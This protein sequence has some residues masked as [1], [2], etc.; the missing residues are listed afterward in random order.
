M[1]GLSYE[2]EFITLFEKTVDLVYIHDFNGRFLDA[3]PAALKLLG[4][5]KE[6]IGTADFSTIIASEQVDKAIETM[7]EIIRIGYQ[8]GF[9]EFIVRNKEGK[10][11]HIQTNG[12]LIYRN[13]KPYA[14][15]GI[16]RDIT[17][18]KKSEE[19]YKKIYEQLKEFRSIINRSPAIVLFWKMSHS[20]PV[21]F[22]SDNIRQFG[23][24]PEDFLS[25]KVSWTGIIH[26]DDLPKFVSEIADCARKNITE[27]YQEYR[28]I[29]ISGDVRWIGDHSKT[30]CNPQEENTHYQSIILDITK[31]K[32]AE[33]IEKRNTK[34]MEILAQK[35]MELVQIS[36]DENIYQ[37]IGNK[38][39]EI[40]GDA[41]II[42]NSCDESKSLLETR[43]VIGLGN[44]LENVVKMLKRHPVGM[45]FKLTDEQ[46][47]PIQR[48]K[49]E[50]I[51]GGIYALSFKMIPQIVCKTLESMLHIADIYGIGFVSKG[52]I[53][54]T[55]IIVTF[56]GA[57]PLDM[58]L[59]E[60]FC[61]QASVSLQRWL[62]EKAVRKS[63]EKYHRLTESIND[64]IY[65]I[66]AQG[67]ITHLGPQILRYGYSLDDALSRDF[68]EFVVPEDRESVMI[69]F[70]RSLTQGEEFPSQFRMRDKK[71]NIRWFEDNGMV[72][73]D[74]HGNIVGLTGI[75]RDITDRKQAEE[76]LK[77][78][79]AK[80]REQKTEL[81]QKNIALREIIG[82]IEIEKNTIKDDVITNVNEI[83]IPFLNKLTLEGESNEY[84]ILF[85][86][87]LENLTSSFGRKISED[88]LKLTPREIEITALIESGLTTKEISKILNISA[89]TVEKHRKNIRKK[90]NIT[91][92]NVNLTTF[93]Q[94]F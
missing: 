47:E 51:E 30:I 82:H 41:V 86:H 29:T 59:V 28:L 8:K 72:Q 76:A 38:L 85:R 9:T 54:G 80:L 2:D 33:N 91:H 71:G 52:N 19:K 73:R 69:D 1:T 48:G 64:I 87:M 75:L 15:L 81:E 23:Y 53:Y 11:I 32:S 24:Q 43:A 34:R 90:L 60:I 17:E 92:K 58:E 35:A 88:T 6:E 44:R 56:K 4:Y 89:Q 21:E 79:E 55:T 25:G 50:K 68:F 14:I 63:E 67:T 74:D 83:L 36:P 5:K 45:T 12:T 26:P 46:R 13:G 20:W 31:R 70:Q 66:D 61:N 27:F 3:N 94:H 37:A 40:T 16:G 22:V 7:K 93:L 10:H 42:I 65:S 18:R 84:F 62:A 39:K 57:E 77:I 78:S 49:L